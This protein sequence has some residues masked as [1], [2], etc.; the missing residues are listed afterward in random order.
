MAL[1]TLN[2]RHT[3]LLLLQPTEGGERMSERKGRGRE[4]DG[5]VR[6]VHIW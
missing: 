6:V 5:E 4:G 3:L 1:H 2:Y